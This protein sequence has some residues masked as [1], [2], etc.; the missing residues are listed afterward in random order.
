MKLLRYRSLLLIY[1]AFDQEK[2]LPVHWIYLVDP[3]FKFNR[4]TE[5]KNMS[6]WTATPGRTLVS[7]ERGCYVGD[8]L[9]KSPDEE[10][11]AGAREELARLPNVDVSKISGYHVVRM[12]DAYPVYDLDFDKH[13]RAVLD[14]LSTV[15]NLYTFGRQGMFLQN[16]MH[17][18]MEAGRLLVERVAA[19]ATSAEWY[20]EMLDYWKLSDSQPLL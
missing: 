6:K 3:T 15:E 19:G 11:F 7:C 13:L 17:D 16:D 12:K 1:V 18:S 2:V 5:Q 20:Q 4:F 10:L 9:W 14:G 8:A